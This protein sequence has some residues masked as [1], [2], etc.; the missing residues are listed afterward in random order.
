MALFLRSDPSAS[1]AALMLCRSE[2][3]C[4]GNLRAEFV[5]HDMVR[6]D[7]KKIEKAKPRH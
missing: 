1:A 3:V 2:A 4:F 5:W 7:S 6:A